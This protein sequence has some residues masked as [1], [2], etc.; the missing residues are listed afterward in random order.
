MDKALFTNHYVPKEPDTLEIAGT[1]TWEHED[2]PEDRR[3]DSIIVEVYADG[4]LTAQRLVTAKDGWRVFLHPAKVCRGRPRC[5]LYH[6]RGR[7]A[8]LHDRNQGI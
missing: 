1:K 7:C 4:E 2:N 3:P 6:R 8:R 5:Y